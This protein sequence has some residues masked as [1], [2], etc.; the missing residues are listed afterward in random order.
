MTAVFILFWARSFA[1]EPYFIPSGSMY[2]TLR[3]GDQVAVE[4][5]SNRYSPPSRGDL[6]VFSP[7]P[8]YYALAGQPPPPTDQWPWERKRLVKRVVA[9]AGDSVEVQEDGVLRRNGRPVYEPYTLQ[10]A[11]YT[12]QPLVVPAGCV[13]VLG[14]N[15]NLSVD[16]HVWGPLPLENLVGK[17][18]YIIWPVRRQ[19]FVDELM[20]DLEITNDSGIFI[21]R[22]EENIRSRGEY[23]R[24]RSTR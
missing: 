18:F 17:A 14:D 12:L 15:R 13:F 21:E 11:R 4:K 8:A 6:I 3:A 1:A 23:A 19:G 16:S 5:F 24:L 7:P 9:V 2:P 22:V 10:K 20:Q